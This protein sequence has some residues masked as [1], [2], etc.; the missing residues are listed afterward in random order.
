M[1]QGASQSVPLPSRPRSSTVAL[2]VEGGRSICAG[3][4]ALAALAVG[5]CGD[6]R[7]SEEPRQIAPILGDGIPAQV[8]HPVAAAIDRL[9]RAFVDDDYEGVCAGMTRAAARHAGEAAHGDVTTCER[10]V[11]RLFELIR[12]GDGWRHAGA[13]R[14]TDVRVD[15]SDAMATVALD[16]RW[17]AR[18]P[19]TREDGRWRLSGF[20]GA[21]P[22]S[23]ER[24]A[25]SIADAAF[26]PRGSGSIE[27]VDG[28]GAPCPDLSEAAFPQVS[29]G[30]R[31]E[32]STPDVPL[33]ILTPLGDFEFERC[34]I[35]YRVRVDASGRTWTEDFE[36]DGSPESVAC[37]DVNACYDFER[38][39][40][41]PWRGRIYRQPGGDFVHRV[42]MCLRTCVGYFVGDLEVRLWEQDGRWRAEPVAGGGDTGFRFHSPLRV[43][44]AFDLMSAE[45]GG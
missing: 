45:G 25:R 11:R 7:G 29:G 13:P 28:D 33:T 35:A 8:A 17:Q 6:E 10:D 1:S 30:C 23:A 39:Q 12:Q 22:S 16:R 15:G 32:M 21:P 31:I 27:V 5:A 3:L 26:P 44:G 40:L 38:E 2:A 34:S 37:G 42:D 36:V 19:L 9:Q 20:F 24:T 41:V 43:K 18:V 4:L 14:V